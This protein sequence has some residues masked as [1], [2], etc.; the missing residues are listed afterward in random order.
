MT[1]NIDLESKVIQ[2]FVVTAK[3]ERYLQFIASPK[4]RQKFVDEL[5]HSKALNLNMFAK[6][7]GP[8][9]NKY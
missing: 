6:V 3:Q 1:G 9:N 8:D 5:A 4:T 7:D 2:R